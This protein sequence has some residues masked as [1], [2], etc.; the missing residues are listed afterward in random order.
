MY[1]RMKGKERREI[2]AAIFRE[3]RRSRVKNGERLR[4]GPL[5]P[6]F[7]YPVRILDRGVLCFNNG[8]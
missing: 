5:T 2:S 7:G 4:A 3:K 8:F 1:A 6:I